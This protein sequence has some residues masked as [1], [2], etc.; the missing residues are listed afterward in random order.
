MNYFDLSDLPDGANV[1]RAEIVLV[2]ERETRDAE[3]SNERIPVSVFDCIVVNRGLSVTKFG[4]GG[5]GRTVLAYTKIVAA[6]APRSSP[7]EQRQP[8]D[9]AMFITEATPS[10]DRPEIYQTSFNYVDLPIEEDLARSLA[11]EYPGIEERMLYIDLLK[12]LNGRAQCKYEP[13]QAR[14]I[15]DVTE[16]VQV[17]ANGSKEFLYF[18]RI[19]ADGSVKWIGPQSVALDLHKPRLVIEFD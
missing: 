6:S 18:F 17:A 1:I 16:P 11:T 10:S 19:V 4:F 12:A 9:V 15:L 3:S 7:G 5:A 13:R 8:P 2:R 14:D